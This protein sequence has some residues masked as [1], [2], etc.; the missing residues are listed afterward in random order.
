MEQ[1]PELDDLFFGQTV[2]SYTTQNKHFLRRE[3]L[4]NEITDRLKK[5]NLPFI[6]LT[7]Q[8]GSG[9]TNFMAQLASEHPDWLC[10]FIRRNQRTPLGDVDAKSFL[11]RLG[12][13]LAGCHPELFDNQSEQIKIVIEQRIGTI[14][15][16][17]EVVGAEVERLLASPFRQRLINIQQNVRQNKG[18]LAGMTVRELVLDQRLLNTAD[19]FSMALLAPAVALKKLQ[20]E[21]QIVILVDALDEILYHDAGEGTILDWLTNAPEL[22]DNIRFV[23][24][25]R[26]PD[27]KVN[28]FISKQSSRLDVLPID[29]ADKRVQKDIDDYAHNLLAQEQMLPI[30]QKFPGR[31]ETFIQ[32]A[33]QKARGNLGYLDVLR[34]G[35][36]QLALQPSADSTK[37]LNTLLDLEEL[38]GEL[39]D[40]YAF[41]LR[42]IKNRLEL[43][44]EGVPVKQNDGSQFILP[45]WEGVYRPILGILAIAFEPFSVEQIKA[46]GPNTASLD[47]VRRALDGLSQFLDAGK[48]LYRLYHATLAEFLSTA[49]SAVDANNQD[50]LIDSR[51]AHARVCAYYRGT[52]QS[53]SQSDWQKIDLYGLMYISSHLFALSDQEEYRHELYGLLCEPFMREKQRRSGSHLAF[54]H[55]VAHAFIAAREAQPPDMVQLAR[56]GMLYTRLN[57][58]SLSLNDDLY[59]LMARLDMTE[60]ALGYVDTVTALDAKIGPYLEIA[61]NLPCNDERRRSLT[62]EAVQFQLARVPRDLAAQD[63]GSEDLI[64]IGQDN[65]LKAVK[66][67]LD[68][69]A[70]PQAMEMLGWVER[71]DYLLIVLN[72]VSQ[73]LAIVPNGEFR[74][75]FAD[76]GWK[77]VEKVQ[78]QRETAIKAWAPVMARAGKLD[79][80]QT[81]FGV[82]A[83]QNERLLQIARALVQRGDYQ[84]ALDLLKYIQDPGKKVAFLCGLAHIFLTGSNFD[85]AR[86]ATHDAL[87]ITQEM[88]AILEKVT[89][90]YATLLCLDRIGETAKAVEM[91]GEALEYILGATG[92]S[93]DSYLTILS[94]PILSIVEFGRKELVHVVCQNLFAAMQDRAKRFNRR[95]L[96]PAAFLI[97]VTQAL[98]QAGD[99]E[100]AH[101]LADLI[102]SNQ[103][104][105]SESSNVSH[106]VSDM[107]LLFFNIGDHQKA[108]ELMDNAIASVE[109]TPGL[110]NYNLKACYDNIARNLI[111]M[112]FHDQGLEFAKKINDTHKQLFAMD[113]LCE[114]LIQAGDL[115]HAVHTAEEMIS[116]AKAADDRTQQWGLCLAVKILLLCDDVDRAFQVLQAA[117]L[118]PEPD[119]WWEMSRA[120]KELI[121]AGKLQTA[122]LLVTRMVQAAESVSNDFDVLMKGSL[123]GCVGVYLAR[124]DAEEKA[125]LVAQNIHYDFCRALAYDRIA[126]VL[127]GS[128]KPQYVLQAAD[129]SQEAAQSS[130]QS[131]GHIFG[132]VLAMA[133][134]RKAGALE[135]ADLLIEPLAASLGAL[136]REETVVE[137]L[138]DRFLKEK[139]IEIFTDDL[140]QQGA[141]LH[142]EIMRHLVFVDSR[143]MAPM[144]ATFLALFQAGYIEIASAS[145]VQILKELP[146]LKDNP[147]VSL[148]VNQ[149]ASQLMN[150]CYVYLL[151]HC[152]NTQEVQ[153]W[154]NKTADDISF[155]GPDYYEALELGQAFIAMAVE[156]LNL[157]EEHERSAQIMS[158]VTAQPLRTA[159]QIEQIVAFA[160]SAQPAELHEKVMEV[161][162]EIE[163]IPDLPASMKAGKWLVQTLVKAGEINLAT[164]VA[165]KS[166]IRLSQ[167]L[168]DL[169][170]DAKCQALMVCAGSLGL[171][172][173]KPKALYLCAQALD[174]ARL[175]S[176]VK[177]LNILVTGVEL[178]DPDQALGVITA[179]EEID[180][181]W[182][183]RSAS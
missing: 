58:I 144:W 29:P 176:S 156:L 76:Q 134:Y 42:Q 72:E 34:R 160:N 108:Q 71:E 32:Q 27:S 95:L 38:T 33:T 106:S 52:T 129:L 21:A 107:S 141:Y 64:H 118:I 115:V 73:V 53:W 164:Q 89:F 167:G 113:F 9:K 2:A 132:L 22:P 30:K 172:D 103:A 146:S 15:D 56:T 178:I 18:R 90:L 145:M 117:F 87:K 91:A 116:V 20:P 11:L 168:T 8:P 131:L 154:V 84:H 88:P 39:G 4:A 137:F 174:E 130:T 50:V 179:I 140:E 54:S 177:V 43:Q 83:Q 80:V 112:G 16:G 13:Q 136:M 150:S 102:L 55:D 155:N 77:C 157:C 99:V 74:D 135:R 139:V 173:L 23:L 110:S 36:E 45:A 109:N 31:M 51:D 44:H 35:I 66:I 175:L 85:I 161:A 75:E 61:E 47:Y 119:V 60:M 94:E 148:L 182:S 68:A 100:M 17:G 166:E 105:L 92:Y 93:D 158:Y 28:L 37:D 180:D 181:W 59:G 79:L 78:A 171:V 14:D 120:A 183:K 26:P 82:D 162:L 149:G 151:W 138:S 104:S 122:K 69:R 96:T 97:K 7:G 19:L 169:S 163:A 6:L 41:F 125:M 57:E 111:R 46:L 170:S 126:Q 40:L 12:F 3:W 121:D 147:I 49:A 143:L 24:S 101:H 81:A 133:A 48:G 10:Y 62:F 165:L 5:Q 159:L 152:G 65:I 70:F 98:G 1:N 124:S 25:S 67:L 142:A 127:A 63:S 128:G 86:T 114:N 153:Q 123:Q